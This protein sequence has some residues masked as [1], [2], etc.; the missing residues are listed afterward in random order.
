[1]SPTRVRVAHSG[2]GRLYRNY[3]MPVVGCQRL[4][5]LTFFM[6]DFSCVRWTFFPLHWKFDGPIFRGPI[7]LV[8]LFTVAVFSVDVLPN[9]FFTWSCHLTPSI[10]RGHPMW[11][12]CS[13]RISFANRV[14]VSA[15]YSRI[16]R[17]RVWWSRSVVSKLNLCC[18]HAWQRRPLQCICRRMTVWIPGAGIQWLLRQCCP[19]LL[20]GRQIL[21]SYLCLLPW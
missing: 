1:M 16:W 6:D 4:K 3:C 21:N 14:H 9:T 7:F 2:A 11:K 19:Q 12:D 15:P 8:D 5:S 20:Q 10:W 13:L 17:T 18:R